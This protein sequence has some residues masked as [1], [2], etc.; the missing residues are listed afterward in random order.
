[1]KAVKVLSII[2]MVLF[3]LSFIITGALAE[4]DPQGAAGWGI[5]A[6]LYGLAYAITVFVK[7]KNL[8]QTA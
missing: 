8:D 1:M 2:G 4:S 7:T 3:P 6:A 5:I